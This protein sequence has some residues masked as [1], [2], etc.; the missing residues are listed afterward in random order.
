MCVLGY[1]DGSFTS[2]F[3]LNIKVDEATVYSVHSTGCLDKIKNNSCSNPAPDGTNILS[4]A[5]F[6]KTMLTWQ[7]NST[8]YPGMAKY[9]GSSSYYSSS[10]IV[11]DA[12]IYYGK[13]MYHEF[14]IPPAD[15]PHLNPEQIIFEKT[16]TSS[17]TRVVFKNLRVP[18]AK[19]VIL[20][21]ETDPTVLIQESSHHFGVQTLN[22][23]SEDYVIPLRSF[24]LNEN[25]TLQIKMEADAADA[26]SPAQGETAQAIADVFKIFYLVSAGADPNIP[27]NWI[28]WEPTNPA[29]PHTILTSVAGEPLCGYQNAVYDAT[30]CPAV[31]TSN[32]IKVVFNPQT[33]GIRKAKLTIFDSEAPDVDL[34]KVEVTLQGQAIVYNDGD[35]KLKTTDPNDDDEDITASGK[36][37]AY[38]DPDYFETTTIT[39]GDDDYFEGSVFTV[40]PNPTYTAPVV[41]YTIKDAD[42]T[43]KCTYCSGDAQIVMNDDGSAQVIVTHGGTYEICVVLAPTDA[44][45]GYTMCA[46]VTVEKLDFDLVDNIEFHTA[47]YQLDLN[48]YVTQSLSDATSTFVIATDK[49]TSDDAKLESSGETGKIDNSLLTLYRL[50]DVTIIASGSF[51]RDGVTFSATD[52]VF[53]NAQVNRGTMMFEEDGEWTDHSSWHRPDI[54]PLGSNHNVQINAACTLS[55]SQINSP[56]PTGVTEQTNDKYPSCYNL[57]IDAENGH[58]GSLVIEPEGALEVINKISN[59]DAERL[60]LAASEDGQGALVFAGAPDGEPMATVEMYCPSADGQYPI[61]QYRS[62]PLADVRIAV[63]DIQCEEGTPII[64]KWSEPLLSNPL[65]NGPEHWEETDNVQPE[66]GYAFAM[67]YHSGGYTCKAEGQLR[68]EDITVDL[69]YSSERQNNQGNNL[70]AN[71]FPAPIDVAKMYAT[72]FENAEATLYFFNSGSYDTYM[73]YWESGAANI[74]GTSPSQV[75]AYPLISGATAAWVGYTYDPLTKKPAA[76]STP[77]KLKIPSGESFCV[78]ATAANGEFTLRAETMASH[79]ASGKMMAPKEEEHFNALGIVVTGGE[80]G[81]RVVLME[82]ENCTDGF[83]NGYDATKLNLFGGPQI[84]ATNRFGKTSVNVA[85]NLTGQYVGFAAEKNGLKYKMS[86]QTNRLDGYTALY[87]Y[88]TKEKKYVDVL[89]GE[90][91]EFTGTHSGEERRFVIVGE[92]EDGEMRTGTEKRI[93]VFGGRMLVSGFDGEDVPVGIYDAQGKLMWQESTEKGPWFELPESLPNGVYFVWVENCQTKFV[94]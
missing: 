33:P 75:Y 40:Y 43:E 91:Y 78:H 56:V 15:M 79:E 53:R 44:T 76:A 68:N 86:F 31:N 60:T 93:D 58:N 23:S 18:M 13:D 80:K 51:V 9:S 87:L 83:D 55:V 85:E 66:L 49:T 19:H 62:A 71:P 94:K 84:Y 14:Y 89:A 69:A 39:F 77:A 54:T 74:F 64:Y 11:G 3:Y 34:S 81:D 26:P 16:G 73:S 20:Y 17:T 36:T 63:D 28:L 2:P 52:T 10:D 35:L 92:T 8:D 4:Q 22:S 82:N 37:I 21:D 72:D 70:I 24:L 7:K 42:N 5:E 25:G 46:M 67:P 90:E 48:D 6:V 45:Y 88:D 32:Y 59:D 50:G 12:E 38:A 57:S 41:G 61:W 29:T 27:T 65:G 1:I 47:M 30:T